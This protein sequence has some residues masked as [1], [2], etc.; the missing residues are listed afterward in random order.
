M[1]EEG[2]KAGLRAL[3]LQRAQRVGRQGGQ[4]WDFCV[5]LSLGE[6]LE[7]GGE[8]DKKGGVRER[9]APGMKSRDS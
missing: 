5:R 1:A 6:R 2:P 8:I 3:K 9:Q 4:R 7:L